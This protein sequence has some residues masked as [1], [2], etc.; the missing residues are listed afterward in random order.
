M[1][2]LVLVAALLLSFCCATASQGKTSYQGEEELKVEAERGFGE[3]LDLWRDGNYE[4]LYDRTAG[5]GTVTREEFAGR[6]AKAP[7]R[8]ACCWE[9]LRD[10][11][12][13]LNNDD[14]ARIRQ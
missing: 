8:P 7:F 6:L 3:L 14:S 9:K 5:G 2:K 12:V 13:V 11:R 4:Q 1:K 10:V